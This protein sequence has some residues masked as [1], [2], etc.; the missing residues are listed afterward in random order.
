M[1][2]NSLP[3]NSNNKTNKEEKKFEPVISGT[4][5]TKKR[6]ELTKF[7][8]S[9]V[10][11]DVH[12]VKNYIL[13]DIIVP[14]LKA[15]IDNVISNGIH[16]LLYGSSS[17][18]KKKSGSEVSYRSYYERPKASKVTYA[19][20]KSSSYDYD[21]VIFE[22][23][24]DADVVLERMREIIEHYNI[25]CVADFYDLSNSNIGT[26]TDNRYGWKNLDNAKVERVSEGFVIRFP[27][28]S[29]ID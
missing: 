9:F 1:D 22:T 16:T 12:T 27:K 2:I 25:V 29:P 18:V 8:G 3:S 13:S 17:G 20:S 4:V 11:E 7:A 10:S 23:R 5:K 28:I 19:S 26:Y 6:S 15:L 24:G 21:D 14:E